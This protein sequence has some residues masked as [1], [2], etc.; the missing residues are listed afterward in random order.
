[1]IGDFWAGVKRRWWLILLGLAWVVMGGFTYWQTLAT[2]GDPFESQLLARTGLKTDCAVTDIAKGTGAGG[3][4]VWQIRFEF[5]DTGG[6]KRS[7]VIVVA[8][9]AAVKRL[10]R[11]AAATVRY[12]ASNPEV[13]TLDGHRRQSL[14]M[15]AALGLWTLV[16]MGGLPLGLTF[17]L[18]ARDAWRARAAAV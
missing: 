12:L 8:D 17:A 13:S 4:P 18:A 3:Q 16:L 11:Q 9:E 10:E 14:S 7:G 2:Y 6:R 5:L 1:M 15:E